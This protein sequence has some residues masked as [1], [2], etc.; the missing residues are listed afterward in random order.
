MEVILYNLRENSIKNDKQMQYEP[1]INSTTNDHEDSLRYE[2]HGRIMKI[3]EENNQMSRTN[4]IRINDEDD[5]TLQELS[6]SLAKTEGKSNSISYEYGNSRRDNYNDSMAIIEACGNETC[7]Q[8]CCPF[9]D[10]LSSERKCIVGQDN[11][12][13]PYVYQNDSENKKLD[14]L[15][16]LTVRDPCVLQGTAHRILNPDEYLFLSNGSLYRDSGEL[17]PSTSYCL[18][19]LDRNIYDATICMYP[20]GFPSYI[21]VC[22]LVSLPFLLLTF[23]VYSILP[24]VQNIHSYTLRVYVASLFITNVIIYC[25]QEIP[26]LSEWKYCIP[27]GTAC[28]NYIIMYCSIVAYIYTQLLDEYTHLFLFDN[29]I[30]ILKFLKA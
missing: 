21:S 18:A 11:Y 10:R 13:F 17:I 23:V 12:S 25:V 27:L 30:E 29:N 9:G 19:V 8:L 3:H 4:S 24:E 26:V 1:H 2:S 14:E 16:Q 15:F 22:L 20:I 28:V 5:S 7:I 6:E